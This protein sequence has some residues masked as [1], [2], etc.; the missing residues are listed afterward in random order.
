MRKPHYHIACFSTD[1]ASETHTH[2]RSCHYDLSLTNGEK[3]KKKKMNSAVG[4]ADGRKRG[5]TLHWHACVEPLEGL[6]HPLWISIAA[7]GTGESTE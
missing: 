3:G 2:T 1:G 6:R 7:C 5:K 4:G